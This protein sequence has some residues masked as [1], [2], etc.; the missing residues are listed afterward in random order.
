MSVQL[1]CS[2]PIHWPRTIVL[3]T[4]CYPF[5]RGLRRM[6]A[7]DPRL[8]AF[9]HFIKRTL[10]AVPMRLAYSISSANESAQGHAFRRGERCIPACAVFH[11]A[12]RLAASINVFTRGLVAH[13]LFA[14]DRVLPVCQS[15]K[16]L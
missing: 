8:D 6:I 2:V 14:R 5:A 3:E 15:P 9:L 11:R 12:H 4:G 7:A 13:E 1:R 16:V 10:H